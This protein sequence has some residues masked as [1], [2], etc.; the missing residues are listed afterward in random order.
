MS[1]NSNSLI[2][3]SGLLYTKWWYE[4]NIL[5]PDNQPFTRGEFINELIHNDE[6]YEKWGNNSC[7]EMTTAERNEWFFINRCG[8]NILYKRDWKDFELDQQAIRKRKPKDE[9]NIIK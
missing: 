3:E 5:G 2:E 7:D 8:G 4:N 6:F 9:S 1:K